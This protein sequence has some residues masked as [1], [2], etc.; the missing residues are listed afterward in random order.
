MAT[1]VQLPLIPSVPFYRVGTTL[2]GRQYIL[3]LRWNG[4]AESWFMDLLAEDETPIRLGIRIVLG[5]LLGGRV[6]S[7]AIPRGRLAASD[8]SNSG[9][10]A[11]LDDLGT[12]VCVYFFPAD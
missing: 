7:T 12:R 8:L 9:R 3:D 1:P 10:E 5:A 6:T 2:A 4:R 11:G